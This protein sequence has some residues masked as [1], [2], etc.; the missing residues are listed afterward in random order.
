MGE[1]VDLNGRRPNTVGS[2]NLSPPGGGGTFDGME[3][4]VAELE[5]DLKD[6]KVD[7]KTVLT[8]LA[9]LRGKFEGFDSHLKSIPTTWQLIPLVFT[10][11]SATLGGAFLILRFGL[12][13]P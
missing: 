4:R 9:Y 2:G 12:P 11:L 5:K 10:I 8:D 1:I 13:H 3:P 6:I 7:M